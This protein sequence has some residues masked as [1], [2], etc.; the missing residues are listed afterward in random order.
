V[1][2]AYDVTAIAQGIRTALEHP[3]PLRAAGPPQAQRFSW[4]TAGATLL[5]VYR[6]VGGA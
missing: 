6:D 5:E 3:A 1:V 4:T 2:D